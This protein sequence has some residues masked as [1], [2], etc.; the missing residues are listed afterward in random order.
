MI[1]DSDKK[2]TSQ[3]E[4]D[5]GTPMSVFRN[6]N[7]QKVPSKNTKQ[8]ISETEF[9]NEVLL[10]LVEFSPNQN[11]YEYLA[12]KIWQIAGNSYVLVNSYDKQKEE[13]RIRSYRGAK[14]GVTKVLEL[15]GKDLRKL[16]FPSYKNIDIL[17]SGKLSELDDPLFALT[18]GKLSRS[19]GN[20]IEKLINIKKKYT[21]GLTRRGELH[22]NILILQKNTSPPLNIPLL[23]T[24][25]KQFSVA[26]HRWLMEKKLK[27]SEERFRLAFNTIPDIVIISRLSDGKMV[28]VNEKF[29]EIGGFTKEEVIGKHS[30]EIQ[31]WKH[32][33]DRIKLID[34]LKK[35]Q[36]VK[37]FEIKFRLK[38]G[39]I[40]EGL[41]SANV[42]HLNGVP[43]ILS[44]TR[45][46]TENIKAEKTKSVL[47][48]ISE[49]AT[50]YGTLQEL[51]KSIHDEL[52]KV[53]DCE[54]FYIALFNEEEDKY[55]FPYHV[56][57]YDDISENEL[58]SLHGSLTDYVRRTGKAC[59]ITEKE[60]KKLM[61]TGEVG[62]VGEPAPVWCGTTLIE[63][64]TGKV[65]GVVTIQNYENP[66]TYT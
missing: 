18:G 44:I 8:T 47:F 59:L 51:S 11:L 25:V 37:N 28:N 33:K 55:S 13:I 26:L 48:N 27:E 63:S 38:S 45:D 12:E 17:L 66:D 40:R 21:I 20:K 22:G 50:R 3:A 36:Q 42:V 60:E 32:S 65:I 43:H 35:H 57:R 2:N 53:V 24:F 7:E 6:E 9:L 41:L 49:R 61:E 4:D 30:D 1:E 46:F 10:D 5:S 64:S 16:H 23:E 31:I 54:N 58:V 39:E 19:I 29:L 15:L 62:H 14:E 52:S 34:L 56:D